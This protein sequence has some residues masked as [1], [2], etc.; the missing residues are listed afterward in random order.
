MPHE[1]NPSHPALSHP[2]EDV[3]VFFV[4]RPEVDSVLEIV[5]CLIYVTCIVQYASLE[6][7]PLRFTRIRVSGKLVLSLSIPPFLEK[8]SYV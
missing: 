3:G 5:I 7:V 8:P 4:V 1:T 6:E 2:Q